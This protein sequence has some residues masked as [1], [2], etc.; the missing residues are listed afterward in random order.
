MQI[1]ESH[2]LM[3]RPRV[4]QCAIDGVA[5]LQIVVFSCME[6]C[7]V[8]NFGGIQEDAIERIGIVGDKGG[9]DGLGRGRGEDNAI[10]SRILRKS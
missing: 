7:G 1:V 3:G 5:M 10:L 2:R 9:I 8:D 6:C 4:A